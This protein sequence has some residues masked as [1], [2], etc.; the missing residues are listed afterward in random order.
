MSHLFSPD[1][2][3]QSCWQVTNNMSLDLPVH[4]LIDW[5]V[6]TLGIVGIRMI[7]C[8]AKEDPKCY[9]E[10]GPLVQRWLPGSG[11]PLILKNLP[12]RVSFH[13]ETEAVQMPTTYSL[14]LSLKKMLKSVGIEIR[15]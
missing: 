6:M 3:V 8:Q 13:K 7:N 15:E 11:R 1:K 14:G 4:F 12:F 2:E 9:G 10:K 5:T